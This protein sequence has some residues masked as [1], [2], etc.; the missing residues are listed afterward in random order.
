M[1][2]ADNS[3]LGFIRV[4]STIL[5]SSLMRKTNRIYISKVLGYYNS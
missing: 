4:A 5:G 1:K 3:G 2:I